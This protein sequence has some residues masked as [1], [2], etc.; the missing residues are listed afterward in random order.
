MPDSSVSRSVA[1]ETRARRKI[2]EA[3]EQHGFEI[4]QM[5]YEPI[6]QMIEMQGRAG[7]W[8]VHV[9]DYGMATGYDWREVV[10]TIH[11][12]APMWLNGTLHG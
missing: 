9:K 1:S 7:G 6:G 3:A 12:N 4:E 11:S 8:Y 2:R 5:D 10:E